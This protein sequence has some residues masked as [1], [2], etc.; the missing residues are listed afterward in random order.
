MNEQLL[1]NGFEDKK[2]LK[3]SA[4]PFL[5]WAGGKTQ[6]LNELNSRLPLQIMQK[7]EIESYIE[8]FVGGG[9][10]FFF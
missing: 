5:K 10:F 4:K 8:P 2:Y 6:L 1:I 3:I 9:A 7:H